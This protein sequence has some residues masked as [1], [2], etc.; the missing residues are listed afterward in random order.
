[1]YRAIKENKLTKHKEKNIALKYQKVTKI[2][3]N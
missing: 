2:S 1:M 3:T